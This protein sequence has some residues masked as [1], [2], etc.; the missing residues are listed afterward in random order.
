[1]FD[2][3]EPCAPSRAVVR[4]RNPRIRHRLPR[5]KRRPPLSRAGICDKP[6]LDPVLT[7]VFEKI[8]TPKPAPITPDPFQLEALEN[9]IDHD[10]LVSAPTGSG[11]TWIAEQAIS[12]C[13]SQG[14]RTWY[15][16][17]LKALSNAIYEQFSRQFGTHLCGILTGDR[18]ENPGAP[19]VVGTT[20]ILRN[21][22]YDAMHQ[23]VSIDTEL[24][25]LD[26][27]HYLSD[28]D[29]GVVWEEVLI[30]LPSRVRLLLL[31]ATI[32][33]AEEIAAWLE[34]NRQTECRIVRSHTRP[35]PLEMLFFFPDGL[36]SPLAGKRGLVPRVK[37]FL[38]QGGQGKQRLNYGD[39]IRCLRTFDLLPAIFFLKSRADCD[40]ALFA[41][42]KTEKPSNVRERCRREVRE[43]LRKYPHLENHRQLGSL[44]ECGVASHHAGQLPYWKVLA[45]KMMGRGYLDAIFSTSTVAAGVNFPARTVV[46][47]Q[48]D[49]FNGRQFSDLTA[50][51][52]HQMT[53]RAGRRG[54]DYIGFALVV[55]GMHQDPQLIYDLK[56]SLPEPLMSQIHINFSMTLNLLLSHS[57]E[58]VKDL[59]DR[60]FASCQQRKR[61]TA[62]QKKWRNLLGAL[63]EELPRGKCDTGDPYEVMEYIQKKKDL[64]KRVKRL[65]RKLRDERR[66]MTHK[67]YLTPGRV[68]LHKNGGMYVVL[69]ASR[70]KGEWVCACHNLSRSL[71]IRKGTMQPKR[72]V[73]TQVKAIL[74]HRLD[75]KGDES[76][77]QLRRLFASL[78]T[79]DLKPLVFKKERTREEVPTEQLPCEGCDHER[80]CHGDESSEVKRLLKEIRAVGVHITGLSEGLWL[81]F[82]RHLRFLKDTGFVDEQDHLS[83]DGEW[84]S[85][86]RL[87]HP[88]LIAEAIRKG[89]FAGISPYMMAGCLAPFV[90]DRFTDMDLV[91]RSPMNLSEIWEAF[92]KV[93]EQIEG[94][95]VLKEM[96]G[97][98][99]PQVYFWPAAALFMWAK[100][101][102]WDEVTSAM[103]VDEGDM[104]SLIVRTADHLRQITNLAE[105]HPDLA[106]AAQKAITL[107][108]REP[109]YIE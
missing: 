98:E 87:D 107:T 94:I 53:G 86:L 17:P 8:G 24:V 2:L 54:K 20:E 3:D 96:R 102:S 16:S 78:Q 64:K 9:I 34:E 42:Q 38:D 90:W 73:S 19:V 7:R 46:L 93:Q 89:G 59:L 44:L 70:V 40:R 109:V 103:P 85:K 77:E 21:Q 88:L 47:V 37:K 1:M 14:M 67:Q 41:C 48:S 4:M 32:S 104:T 55:P 45:E 50:T 26:E 106:A 65:S 69:A 33:N 74:D 58:E 36:I 81:S 95:R 62:S 91:M 6:R 72:V 76:P 13:L 100:G 71:R 15:A 79:Q 25:I 105:S 60:S 49:R 27:A 18:K 11:K 92:Q 29:R 35:V 68:F 80:L 39:I 97:F 23:G 83:S 43:F 57:P 84:A 56:D 75:L 66:L 99:N 12:R 31:S 108:L 51:E 82:K 28:P 30:Y 61:E 52:L 22:L 10:V 63:K 5:G 101:Y